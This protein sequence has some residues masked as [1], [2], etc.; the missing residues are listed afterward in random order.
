MRLPIVTSMSKSHKMVNA[1]HVD[2]TKN[3]KDLEEAAGPMLAILERRLTMMVLALLV[4]H[5]KRFPRI[6]EDVRHAHVPERK[7]CGMD[8]AKTAPDIL[9]TSK[10]HARQLHAETMRKWMSLA[11]VSLADPIPRLRET[12][13]AASNQTAELLEAMHCEMAVANLALNTAAQTR[14]GGV[15]LLTVAELMIY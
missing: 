8:G 11:G 14:Q 13:K 5:L 1:K 4:Q 2:L 15:V 3:P 12:N 7:F 6:N 10:A 9:E